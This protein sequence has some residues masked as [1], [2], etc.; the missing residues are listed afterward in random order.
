MYRRGIRVG[1]IWV[2]GA[3]VAMTVAGASCSS[4][5]PKTGTIVGRMHAVGGPAPGHD[6]RIVGRVAI[7][8]ASDGTVVAQVNTDGD[9]RFRVAV[10]PGGYRVRGTSS[11]FDGALNTSVYVD[12]GRTE[13]V[14][15]TLPVT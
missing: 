6:S 1:R 7:S 13:S 4:S 12:P 5:H 3:A 2:I 8:R 15:L 9:G 10:P 11:N 14:V